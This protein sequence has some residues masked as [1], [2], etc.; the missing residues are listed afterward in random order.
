[1]QITYARCALACCALVCV[2][3]LLLPAANVVADAL[4][5]LLLA[6]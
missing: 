2:T 5:R 6:L 3:A 1:M 4:S